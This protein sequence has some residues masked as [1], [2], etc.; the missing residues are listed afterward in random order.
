ML[1]PMQTAKVNGGAVT[2]A[3]LPPSNTLS[4]FN[5]ENCRSLVV[6]SMSLNMHAGGCF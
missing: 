4:C 1:H 3:Q 2:S 6:H 5:L